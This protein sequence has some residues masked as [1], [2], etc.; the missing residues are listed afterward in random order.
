MHYFL[1][2]CTY[3]FLGW[4]IDTTYRSFLAQDL[5]FGGWFISLQIPVPIAPVYGFG[6]LALILL[7]PLVKRMPAILMGVVPGLIFTLVE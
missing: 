4:I 5:I 7:L 1:Y 2:F 6:A 3:S